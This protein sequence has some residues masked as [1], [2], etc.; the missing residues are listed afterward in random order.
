MDRQQQEAS[1]NSVGTKLQELV[2]RVP[3][4]KGQATH[5]QAQPRFRCVCVRAGHSWAL[6][7]KAVSLAPACVQRVPVLSSVPAR[8]ST[9]QR[10]SLRLHNAQRPFAGVLSSPFL[11]HKAAVAAKLCPVVQWLCIS[12]PEGATQDGAGLLLRTRKTPVTGAAQTSKTPRLL[13]QGAQ[14]QD[15]PVH[16]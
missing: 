7:P 10:G 5:Q 12:L 4:P 2:F 9:N 8:C 13:A 16:W 6:L 1:D 14:N 3:Y 15:Q 11:P